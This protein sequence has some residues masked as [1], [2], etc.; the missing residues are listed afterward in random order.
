MDHEALAKQLIR[1]LRGKRSQVALS[2]RMKCRSNVVYSWESGRRWPTA[3]TFFELAQRTGVDL[4]AGFSAFLGTLPDDLVGQDLTAPE[5][6]GKFLSHLREGTT[7]VELARKVGTNRVSLARWLKGEAEPRL[8]E[9]LRVVDASSLRLLD[10]LSVFVAP[11]RLPEARA[12]WQVLEAQ[13]TLAY[14]LPWSHAVM[15]VLELRAYRRLP[16]HRL[17]FIAERLGI[18]RSDEETCLN[19]LAASKLIEKKRKRW[20]IT[21]VLTVDTRRNPEAGRVLK[22]HWA[23]VALTRLPALEPRENDLF[24]Y[25]LFTVSEKDWERLRELHIAYYQELRRLIEASEPAERVALVN[26]QLMRL[27]EPVRAARTSSPGV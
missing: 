4:T 17:G 11:N 22:Q 21:Q 7:L 24:S 27:D 15:R 14:S 10:F 23:S 9:L 26:L 19:A 6:V 20:V 8:P 5:M 2:R 18:S 16:Q 1:A 12:A 3:A 25:N 13:R